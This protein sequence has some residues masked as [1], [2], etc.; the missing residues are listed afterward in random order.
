MALICGMESEKALQY[1][2]TQDLTESC[3]R[4]PKS[5]IVYTTKVGP[6]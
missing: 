6:H 3:G 2:H 4:E 1:I 5:K